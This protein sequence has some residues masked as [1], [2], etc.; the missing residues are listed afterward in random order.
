[1][2]SDE[3]IDAVKKNKFHVWAVNKIDDGIRILTDTPAGQ[4]HKDGTFTKD[5]VFELV[6]NRLVEF[7]T[8]AKRFGKILDKAATKLIADETAEEEEEQ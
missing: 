7:S 8:N 3:V 4:K 6:R 1:M 2:L 5:S